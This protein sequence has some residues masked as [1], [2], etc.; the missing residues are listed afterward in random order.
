[1]QNLIFTNA[2]AADSAEILALYRSFIG[3]PADWNEL[4]PNE[5]T[6]EFDLGRNALFCMKN[7][8]G[9][10][11]ATISADDD[12]DVEALTLWNREIR[13]AAEVSRICVRSDMQNKGVAGM[14]M[15]N[16]FEIFKARGIKMVH[17]LVHEGH[18]GALR[19]YDKV[20]F[21][22][23]GECDFWGKHFICMERQL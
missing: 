17:I 12:K 1:M 3:G 15:A 21:V 13:P 11:V 10:I 6:I 23:V 22:K 14:L 4:Y 7:S 18:N 8:E 16:I 9:E 2:T 20:G 5:D 19:A